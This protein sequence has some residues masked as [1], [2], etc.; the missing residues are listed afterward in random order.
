MNHIE[1]V[2]FFIIISE[3]EF[4]SSD[5]VCVCVCLSACCWS[6]FSWALRVPEAA[7]TRDQS[8]RG[9]ETETVTVPVPD[10]PQT[11]AERVYQ[12]SSCCL[13]FYRAL[14]ALF[15]SLTRRSARDR[16]TGHIWVRIA[17]FSLLTWLWAILSEI[18][19][20][21]RQCSQM[22]RFQLIFG[23]YLLSWMWV[24]LGL[25]CQTGTEWYGI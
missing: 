7:R 13:F 2:L 10:E 6:Q 17:R 23:S 21:K 25:K 1:H 5:A 9:T 16:W 20:F 4:C 18:W 19:Y 15:P 8:Q 12:V 22:W 11:G 3:T 14:I 24:R